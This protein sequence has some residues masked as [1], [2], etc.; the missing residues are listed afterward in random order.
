VSLQ[1]DSKGER[2]LE[3]SVIDING[4]FWAWESWY[5]NISR[6]LEIFEVFSWGVEFECANSFTSRHKGTG[7]SNISFFDA[8]FSGWGNLDISN[9]VGVVQFPHILIFSS[10]LEAIVGWSLVI[11]IVLENFI[12]ELV[13][14]FGFGSLREI[15]NKSE[16]RDDVWF[17]PINS[18]LTNSPLSLTPL[19]SDLLLLFLIV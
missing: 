16:F 14:L 19:V 4:S 1:V 3:F 2:N 11:E 15:V 10:V 9:S 18:N 12:F 6:V 8:E 13:D 5:S 7:F 17:L